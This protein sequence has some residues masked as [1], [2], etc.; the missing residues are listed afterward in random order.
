MSNVRRFSLATFLMLASIPIA[1]GVGGFIFHEQTS[2][3]STPVNPVLATT[4]TETSDLQELERRTQEAIRKILPTV[5]AV[6]SSSGQLATQNGGPSGVI[7]SQDGLVLSQ[8][9]VSHG[10]RNT[11]RRPGEATTVILSDGRA[12]EAKLL[13]A[14]FVHDLSLLQI[15]E[16]GSYP[17]TALETA[18]K[19]PV[20]EWVLKLGHP[21]GYQAGRSPVCR[22]GRV[23]YEDESYFVTDCNLS[24]GDSGGP[25][26]NL[27]G[28]FVG[29]IKRFAKKE[30][31]GHGYQQLPVSWRPKKN[32]TPLSLQIATNPELIT[33]SIAELKRG[34][35]ITE[36]ER[37]SLS[38][39]STVPSLSESEW[40]CG[41]DTAKAFWEVVEPSRATVVEIVDATGM[42]IVLG[43]AVD[44]THVLTVAR[45]LPSKPWCRTYVK[46]TNTDGCVTWDGVEVVARSDEYDLALLRVKHSA[47]PAQWSTGALDTKAGALLVAPG[48]KY[49]RWDPTIAV[50]IVSV[51]TRPIEPEGPTLFETDMPLFTNQLGGPLVGLDGKVVGMS[52]K[53][54]KYG[55]MAIPADQ[56]VRIVEQMQAEK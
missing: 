27:E 36:G 28:R 21:T 50:G 31:P 25:H 45:L 23:L 54:T 48:P 3:E 17:F 24:G 55:C 14:D 40:T 19:A 37:K 33:L 7:I 5:V 51:P 12:V 1:F 11:V 4:P 13:G 18:E 56:L 10:S 22:L 34:E 43:V 15:T 26:F 41:A 6:K 46:N 16:P 49:F 2:N 8:A 38:I 9:H 30:L 44:R 42:C 20:G 35:V 32:A 53:A 29:L 52:I 39:E 47:Q